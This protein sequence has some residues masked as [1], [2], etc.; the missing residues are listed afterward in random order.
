MKILISSKDSTYTKGSVGGAETS[1]RLL[2]EKLAGNGHKVYYVAR[3][4]GEGF[5]ITLKKIHGV[6]VILYPN[7][8][9]GERTKAG[10]EQTRIF[11]YLKKIKR[12][13]IKRLNQL[14]LNRAVRKSKLDE[15]DV[16]Y[17]YDQLSLL[18]FFV[19]KRKS[20][21][22]FKIVMRMA[23]LLWYKNILQG[24]EKRRSFRE[25]FDE[26]DAVN[27]ISEGLK[28]L[29]AKKAAEIEFELGFRHSFVGDIGVDFDALP[30]RKDNEM[31]NEPFRI[32]VA[33]RFSLTQKRHDL[34]VEAIRL[35]DSSLA[36][37]VVMI[38]DG[39]R[40]VFIRK[41]IRDYELDGVIRVEPFQNQE[42]LWRVMLDADLLCHPTNYEGF[43][44]I[45]VESMALGIPVLA[46]DVLPLNNY[47][48]DGNTG[49]LVKNTPEAWAARLT[50]II[51]EREKLQSVSKASKEWAQNNLSADKCV[52]LYENEFRQLLKEPRNNSRKG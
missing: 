41:M 8:D 36:L 37:E 48:N 28:D 2:A 22:R 18:R 7:F 24:P 21:A 50:R 30:E 11:A 16:V 29:A 3:K 52:E 19:G 34:L 44:K 51:E 49:F 27:Y 39:P 23:G 15:F 5:T 1:M 12:S 25:I 32:V 13:L 14:M 42:E 46:S 43:G 17:V 20:G 40:E 6:H 35:M 45:V 33:T 26:L 47:I 38:G 4:R 9:P 10:A 31:N